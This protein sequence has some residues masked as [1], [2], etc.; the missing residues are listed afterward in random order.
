MQAMKLE[1]DN[2]ADRADTAEQQSKE[3]VLRAEKAEEEVRALQKKI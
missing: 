3:A 2:A 1:K